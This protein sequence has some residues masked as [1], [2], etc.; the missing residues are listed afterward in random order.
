MNTTK[1]HIG[2]DHAGY[3]LKENLKEY[4]E[5]EGYEVIDHGADEYDEDDDYPDFCFPVAENVSI[6]TNSKGIVLGG[7]G[8][9]EAIAANRIKG[10]RA[11][12]FN[13]QYEPMDGRE[14]PAEI[15]TARQ[16][17]DSNVLSLG[18]RF[19]SNE[20]AL[21]AVQTWLETDFSGEE[22]HLRRIKKLDQLGL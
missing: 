5:K 4:L 10:V 20:E 3:E 8:Q 21:E 2:S 9:G 15:I 12:V 22:R 6:D 13:G 1:I 11:V 14:V 18:A 17:N 16:H 7:S 19:L